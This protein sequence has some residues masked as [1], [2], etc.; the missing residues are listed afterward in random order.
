MPGYMIVK[1]KD[2]YTIF[3]SFNFDLMN[4]I[5]I[6]FTFKSKNLKDSFLNAP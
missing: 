1:K 5:L 6:K 3:T 4:N 2:K